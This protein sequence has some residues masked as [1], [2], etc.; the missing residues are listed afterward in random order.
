[1]SA[2]LTALQSPEITALGPT[3]DHLPSIFNDKMERMRDLLDGSRN[4]EAYN[5]ILMVPNSSCIPVLGK[6]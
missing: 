1:M 2:I 3:T 5:A 6:Q 4:Y